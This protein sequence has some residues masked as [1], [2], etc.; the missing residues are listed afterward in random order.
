MTGRAAVL[1]L[2]G[3]GA[4]WVD[5]CLAAGWE[6]AGFDPDDRA[7]AGTDGGA[8]WHREATI[9]AAVKGA[10]WVICCLPERLELMRTV[11]QRAQAS[12]AAD[13]VIAVASTEHDIEAVQGCAIRPAY[14]FRLSEGEAG[15]LALDVSG[16]NDQDLRLR[17]T[18]ALAALSA[19]QSVSGPVGTDPEQAT[20][21]SRKA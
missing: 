18:E 8:A 7:S 6:V 12:A 13:A 17:A 19:A 20:S 1:G 10:S 4:R 3:R 2:G 16:R 11:I 14:V 9:S 5:T 15:E 21:E